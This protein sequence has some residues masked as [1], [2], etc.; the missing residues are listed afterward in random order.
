[1]A[2]WYISWRVSVLAGQV[3]IHFLAFLLWVAGLF[4][5]G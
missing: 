4:P 1:M 2:E 3:A 5:L